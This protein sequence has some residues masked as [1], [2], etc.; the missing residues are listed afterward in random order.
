[1]RGALPALLR[2][3]RIGAEAGESSQMLHRAF[4]LVEA[5]LLQIRLPDGSTPGFDSG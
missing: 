5:R 3:S 2:S 1:M 4:D